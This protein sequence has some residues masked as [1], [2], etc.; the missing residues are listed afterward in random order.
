MRVGVGVWVW[1]GVRVRVGVWIGVGVGVGVRVEVR[2]AAK[3]HLRPPHVKV[4][5]VVFP[6]AT[7]GGAFVAPALRDR[8][9]LE[10]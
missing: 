7:A 4:P 5:L 9:P 2:A 8:E 1:V 6:S 3:A 10:G